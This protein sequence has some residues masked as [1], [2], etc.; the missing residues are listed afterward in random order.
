[1]LDTSACYILPTLW[2]WTC[3][4]ILG[5]ILDI[6]LLGLRSEIVLG[7]PESPIPIVRLT[8]NRHLFRLASVVAVALVVSSTSAI[9]S[10]GSSP[11]SAKTQRDVGAVIFLVLTALQ[12]IQTLIL[13]KEEIESA[14]RLIRLRYISNSSFS[15]TK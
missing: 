3:K 1:M 4:S 13:A 8:K 11:S 7:R 15:Y 5:F 6:N 10:D 2:Y 14:Y 12:A 9:K